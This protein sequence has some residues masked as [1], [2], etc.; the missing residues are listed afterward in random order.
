MMGCTLRSGNPFI[1][2]FV[3]QSQCVYSAA[4]GD[5]GDRRRSHS[6]AIKGRKGMEGKGPLGLI[7]PQIQ[8]IHT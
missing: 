4:L 1:S 8:F 7:V 5:G 6:S 3:F 2:T